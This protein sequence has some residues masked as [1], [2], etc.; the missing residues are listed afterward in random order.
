M[1]DP[2]ALHMEKTGRIAIYEDILQ[3]A[4]FQPEVFPSQVALCYLSNNLSMARTTGVAAAIRGRTTDC[5]DA[6]SLC[7]CRTYFKHL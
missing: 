3:R 6:S 1:L 5:R 2:S 4:N 7:Q